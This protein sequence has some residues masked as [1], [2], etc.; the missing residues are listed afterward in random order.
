MSVWLGID[1]GTSSAKCVAI[2]AHGALVATAQERYGV[3]R[4][5]PGWAEQ[6]PERWWSATVATLRAV[7]QALPAGTEIKSIGLSGQMHGVVLVDAHARPVRP[8]IIWSDARS[9]DE[10]ALWRDE[11]GDDE[12][13]AVTGFRSAHGF[14]GPSLTWLRRHEPDALA[15]AA[16]V[17]QPKDYVRLRL[18]GEAA[19]EMCDA[20]GSLL[21][22][23]EAQRPSARLLEVAGITPEML[24]PLRPTLGVAGT[25]RPTAAE[26]TGVP[27]GTIVAAGGSDQAM[28]ALALGLE[29]PSRAAVTLSSGGTVLVPVASS[30]PAGYHRL[31]AAQAGRT[32]AMGVV[33][34]AGL[35]TDWLARLVG[36]PEKD[37]LEA[38]ATAE[39]DDT[40]AATPH[41]GGTRTPVVST[42]A[43]GA[44]SGVGFHHGAEHLMRAL[45]EGTAVSLADSLAAVSGGRIDASTTIVLSGGGSRFAVW[46]Q[47]VADAT[48]VPVVISS[49]LEHAALGAALSGAAAEGT[50]IE[51]HA[52]ERVLAVVEPDAAST[53]RLARLRAGASE[54][55]R[56]PKGGSDE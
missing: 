44:F 2:D 19:L 35:A 1:L 14:A 29:D 49:D 32:I 16:H 54:D 47:A 50:P 36:R 30:V 5:H 45:V 20:G 22:D 42:R 18:T 53:Q 24:P 23:L 15:A 13:E 6:D 17:M 52:P 21:F 28:T 9:G 27:A 8:A 31:A 3:D 48:G 38:A 56:K 46:R 51:F 10:V 41:L 40:L 25:V 39:M 12:L 26:K 7:T 33:L 11:I 4:P 37:L 43:Q 34:A 55:A